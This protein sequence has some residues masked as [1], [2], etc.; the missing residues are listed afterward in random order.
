MTGIR[1]YIWLAE[2]LPEVKHV[3]LNHRDDS[4]ADILFLIEG[5]TDRLERAI[6]AIA[7]V[8]K[9]EANRDI[10][11]KIVKLSN[12]RKELDLIRPFIQFG[13]F[14]FS[15]NTYNRPAELK[16]YLL[17]ILNP[18]ERTKIK[19]LTNIMK[20]KYPRAII[21]KQGLLLVDIETYKAIKKTLRD[22]NLDWMPL[23]V[24]LESQRLAEALEFIN[25]NK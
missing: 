11:V 24:W 2:S 10:N 18:T 22:L 20:K 12:L 3:I 16:K 14:L 23:E 7:P 25:K 1:R 9:K 19:E 17:I 4:N 5:S 6:K 21:I 15:R 8:V 13:I